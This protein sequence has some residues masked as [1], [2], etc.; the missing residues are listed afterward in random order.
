MRAVEGKG[1]GILRKKKKN[2]GIIMVGSKCKGGK[3]IR[4]LEAALGTSL[5]RF[6]CDG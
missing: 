2:L 5:K 6:N 3:K 1:K 4:R